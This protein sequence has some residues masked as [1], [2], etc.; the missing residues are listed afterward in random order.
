LSQPH[1]DVPQTGAP[2]AGE[3]VP[4]QEVRT[5]VDLYAG[6]LMPGATAGV[7]SRIDR[8]L[9]CRTVARS[10]AVRDLPVVADPI[11]D[12]PVRAGG[13]LFDL[14]DYVSRNRVTGLLVMQEGAVRLEHYEPGCGPA[15]RWASMSMAKSI[16][17]TLLGAAV[18]DGHV[19]SIDEAVV[20]YLPQLAGS[21]YDGVSIRQLIQMTSGVRWS[22]EQVD[23]ASERRHMLQLQLSGT[24]GSILAYMGTLPRVAQPGT[25]WNYSTGET[26][27]VG[28]L[29]HAATGRWLADYLSDR[30]WSRL[31][32]EQ[33]AAWQL[34]SSGGLEVGGSGICATLR[35]YA[36]FGLFM[37]G[38]GTIDG[39]PVLPPGWV[40]EATSARTVG[41]ARV[42][43]GY[44]W[45]AV[46]DARGS[47]DDGAYS[48]RGIFGQYLY[49][50]PRRRI[51]I[52]VLSARAKPRGAEAILDNDFF[53]SVVEA[54]KS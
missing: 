50:N 27:V 42:D 44:M 36:R 52:A 21:A 25:V 6:K 22:D 7:L 16:A 23:P 17:T 9:P 43:Y 30:V 40:A 41:G 37:M 35:D 2:N 32:M 3:G 47:L 24:P 8:M 53:N 29:V 20:R 1:V 45:W 19:S 14:A 46:P 10:G 48:A 15:T 49:V 4:S 51:L 38:G 11:G 28:A 34:E 26:H 5:I 12:V 54:L 13:Q 39:E 18:R 33:D 31:G